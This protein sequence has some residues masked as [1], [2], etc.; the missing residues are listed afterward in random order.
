MRTKPSDHMQS[1]LPGI[2]CP[3]DSHPD[4]HPYSEQSASAGGLCQAFHLLFSTHA[5]AESHNFSHCLL[6]EASATL[7]VIVSECLLPLLSISDSVSQH[8]TSIICFLSVAWNSAVD[9]LAFQLICFGWPDHCLHVLQVSHTR[10][11]LLGQMRLSSHWALTSGAP[12]VCVKPS[13]ARSRWACKVQ[14][15]RWSMAEEGH[16]TGM[17]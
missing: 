11:M 10:A 14:N 17:S 4:L 6:Q 13:T 2:V 1:S 3:S 16:S 9:V 12:K 7:G 15:C 5:G 8:P